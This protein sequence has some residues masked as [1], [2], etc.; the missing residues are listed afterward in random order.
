MKALI[1]PVFGLLVLGSYAFVMMRGIDPGAV[2]AD[3]RALPPEARAAGG[4]SR[5]GPGFWFV[6]A[7]FGGGK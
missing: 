2:S 3:T 4:A 5:A 6:G 7:G 1:Y